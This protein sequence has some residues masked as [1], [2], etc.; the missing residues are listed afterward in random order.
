MVFHYSH[1]GCVGRDSFRV[2]YQSDCF[3]SFSSSSWSPCVFG[4]GYLAMTQILLLSKKKRKLE[5]RCSAQQSMQKRVL[6]KR[7]SKKNRERAGCFP[8]SVRMLYWFAA[9]AKGSTTQMGVSDYLN[10]WTRSTQVRYCSS[11]RLAR[12]LDEKHSSTLLL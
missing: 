2:D 8:L 9:R 7:A 4:H 1:V 6:P 11:L 10:R 5:A 3:P 12:S